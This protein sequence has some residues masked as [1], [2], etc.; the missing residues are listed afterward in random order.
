MADESAVNPAA[1]VKPGYKTTEFWLTLLS[2]LTGGVISSG[3][4]PETSPVMK[5]AGLLAMILGAFGYTVSRGMAK[6]AKLLLVGILLSAVLGGC[7]Y[8]D[9]KAVKEFQVDDEAMMVELAKYVSADPTKQKP[10]PAHPQSTIAQDEAAEIQ[11][12]RAAVAGDVRGVDPAEEQRLV[13]TFLA[14]V[15]SD[16]RASPG[17]K[18]AWSNVAR[19]HL[20]LFAS[21]HR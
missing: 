17:L 7:R 19:S 18:K 13:A 15:Q 2:M 10:S 4:F 12:H 5:G 16:P 6:G 11:N 21:V 9:E 1:A 3:L 14:Y 20:D 8:V